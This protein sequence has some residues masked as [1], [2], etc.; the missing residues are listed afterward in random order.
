MT[1]LAGT[2]DRCSG[3]EVLHADA[4]HELE[5]SPEPALAPAINHSAG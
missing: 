3:D 2:V 4:A 5:W 1:M